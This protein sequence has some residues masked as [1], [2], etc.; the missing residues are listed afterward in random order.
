MTIIY[1]RP[2]E[3]VHRAFP[4]NPAPYFATWPLLFASWAGLP[5]LLVRLSPVAWRASAWR[6][7]A[8]KSPD[9][10]L[11]VP[12]VDSDWCKFSICAFPT[13]LLIGAQQDWTTGSRARTYFEE[14]GIALQSK[15]WFLRLGHFDVDD[16]MLAGATIGL[17]LS[18]RYRTRLG[19]QRWQ[20]WAGGAVCG[21]FVGNLATR[22]YYPIFMRGEYQKRKQEAEAAHREA[23]L[24]DDEV[25]ET[26]VQATERERLRKNRPPAFKPSGV[27]PTSSPS[28]TSRAGIETSLPLGPRPIC[29]AFQASRQADS[30]IDPHG[31]NSE[32][33]D[34]GLGVSH[35][36]W[37]SDVNGVS[38]NLQAYLSKLRTRRKMLLNEARTM[39]TWLDSAERKYYTLLEATSKST[40]QDD[41]RDKALRYCQVLESEHKVI[42]LAISRTDWL[43]ANAQKRIRHHSN[44]S[45]DF[46]PTQEI[47]PDV[48]EPPRGLRGGYCKEA[49]YDH[50]ELPPDPPNVSPTFML[51]RLQLRQHADKTGNGSA[52]EREPKKVESQSCGSARDREV[53]KLLIEDAKRLKA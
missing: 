26:M 32:L 23:R 35:C 12:S 40:A 37:T 19:L 28:Q 6:N 15:R 29:I 41:E 51:E 36:H 14:K 10:V 5:Y 48:V 34:G 20:K 45:Q 52:M 47:E 30:S 2:E 13:L 7:W 8:R 27:P 33:E 31:I 17:L 21:S 53:I 16:G 22:C 11:S 44:S 49:E 50:E 18:T 4:R 1:T 25:E 42:W 43:V 24:W 39:W 3:G 46:Q 9:P 38:E